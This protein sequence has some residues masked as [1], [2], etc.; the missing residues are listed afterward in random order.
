MTTVFI[1]QGTVQ[2]LDDIKN[3]PMA[4]GDLLVVGF[5]KSGTS[6]LQVMI[7]NLWDHWNTCGELRKVPSLHGRNAF[8][9]RYYGYADCLAL[10]SPR[11]MK[12]HLPLELMPSAWPD[13]GQVVH[14]TRNPKDVCIS[15]F[16][17]LRHMQRTDPSAEV[18]IDDFDTHFD[19]FLAGEV[20]WGPYPHNVLGWH[21]FDHPGL[22][23]ITYEDARR[24]TADVLERIVNFVGRPVSADRVAEVVR[25]TEFSAMKA[26]GVRSQINHPDMREDTETPFMRKG[27]VGDWKDV[28]TVE[29]NERFERTVVAPLHAAGLDLVYE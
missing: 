21:E 1:D 6:W 29:Q 14:I 9:G 27:I 17:E 23:K 24:N 26:S 18:Q 22:L 2:D 12:T 20:P 5:P 28:F 16:H 13:H 10:E 7:T 3:F 11:L 4:D 25:S 8:E 15:L 19:R